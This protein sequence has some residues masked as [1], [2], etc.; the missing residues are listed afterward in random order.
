MSKPKNVVYEAANYCI[1]CGGTE[2]PLTDEHIVPFSLGGRLIFPKASCVACQKV[3]RGFNEA[4]AR[5]MY[6]RMRIRLNV[7]TRK[8]KER[9]TE[10]SILAIRRDGTE[11]EVMVPAELYPRCY[12]VFKFKRAG[13]LSDKYPA[14]FDRELRN[15]SEDMAELVKQGY[16][17]PDEDIGIIE[18][19]RV[20][21]FCEQLAQIGHAHTVAMMGMDSF[22]PL[23]PPL[24]LGNDKRY[25]QL[26]GGVS[27]E[28]AVNTGATVDFINHQG[29]YFVGCRVGLPDFGWNF[30]TYQIICGR[31]A[32]KDAMEAAAAKLKA[33]ADKLKL[34]DGDEELE[35]FRI[36]M[37]PA[38]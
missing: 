7:P 27:K 12:T 26:I 29:T 28:E 23:L 10:L 35:G 2:P 19:V 20:D 6:G 22:E 11:R 8:P 15:S 4:I 9:P 31:F 38:E 32:D 34:I 14:T 25:F 21:A 36:D 17:Q 5:S 13:I 24:I 30:P 37:A 1:Y 33:A 18:H 3:T 16:V